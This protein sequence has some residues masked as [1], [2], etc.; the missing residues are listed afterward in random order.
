MTKP[1]V[2]AQSEEPKLG[3]H[4]ADC[5]GQYR[6]KAIAQGIRARVYAYGT[7]LCLP[8]IRPS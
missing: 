8:I 7:N 6:C 1:F 2:I 5:I 3:V 4:S